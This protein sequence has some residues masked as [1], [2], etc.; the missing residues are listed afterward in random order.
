MRTLVLVVVTLLSC[1]PAVGR[2]QENTEQQQLSL[3]SDQGQVP[4]PPATAR[5]AASTT[6][7][8]QQ[9]ADPFRWL[10]NGK[11]PEVRQ[12]IKAQNSHTDAVISAM[13]L[14]ATM[15]SRVRELAIT[16]TTRS[17]PHLIDGTLFF[18]R[19]VPPQAQPVLV[20]QAWP[21]GRPR[22]LVD[23]NADERRTAITAFWPSPDGRHLAWG[24][25]EGGSELTTIHVLDVKTGK[26]TG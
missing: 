10:E 23:P 16:S 21:E 2:A 7:H 5:Q 15:N 20:A 22:V 14:G 13:P 3:I 11:A 1:A 9:V 25:A 26:T 4:L 18:L 24:T 6:M 12:W 19:Q 8:G 17:S